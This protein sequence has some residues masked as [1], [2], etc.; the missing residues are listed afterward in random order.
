MTTFH[1]P[2]IKLLLASGSPF[3]RQLLEQAGYCVTVRVPGIDEPQLTPA[4]LPQALLDLAEA[5]ARAVPTFETDPVLL[6]AADTVSLVRGEILG[7]PVDRADASRMLHRM[8]GTTHQVLTAICLLQRQT[9]EMRRVSVTTELTM[10]SWDTPRINA[11]LDTGEWVGKCGGYGL[12][13]T[14]DPFIEQITG[15]FSNVIGL[16]LERLEQVLRELIR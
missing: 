3:R 16:P 7:K 12:E 8:S 5:K 15:S 11:Y 2:D 6:L 9:G 4:Q 10:K 1:P 13:W 14:G